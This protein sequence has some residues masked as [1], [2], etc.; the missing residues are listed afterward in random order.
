MSTTECMT[1]TSLSP[2]KAPNAAGPRRT[3]ETSSFGTPTGSACI[4]ARAE[5]R[6][7]GAAEAEH[8]VDRALGEQAHDDS[9]HALAHQRDGRA[10]R[11]RGRT[12]SSA[13]RRRARPPAR[14]VGRD[15]GS[16]RMPESITTAL[17][18]R[19]SASRT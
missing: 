3:G 12:S 6:A 7:L 2:T 15:A 5:Q 8:A 4:A 14:D 1:Q 9:P 11:A 17:T 19:A 10:A 18:E 13:C 16:P